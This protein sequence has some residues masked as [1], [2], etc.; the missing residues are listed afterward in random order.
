MELSPVRKGWSFLQHERVD[1]ALSIFNAL[2]GYVRHEG[3][4]LEGKIISAKFESN[5]CRLQ[6]SILWLMR[7]D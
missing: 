3:A 7:V 4:N 1:D 2:I 5:N 6:A